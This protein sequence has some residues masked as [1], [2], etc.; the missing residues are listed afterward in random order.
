MVS[1]IV[2][3]VMTL[4]SI[5]LGGVSIY[6]VYNLQMK[7]VKR[8]FIK[9]EQDRDLLKTIQTKPITKL[10][11]V[12]TNGRIENNNK[13]SSDNNEIRSRELATASEDIDRTESVNSDTIA[14]VSDDEESGER[15][16]MENG[17]SDSSRGN[18]KRLVFVKRRN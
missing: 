12:K 3:V 1:P 14:I 2:W 6:V 4:L 8:E 16:G 9:I 15:R 10:E 13:A 18:K 5:I 17:N 7:K 11:E